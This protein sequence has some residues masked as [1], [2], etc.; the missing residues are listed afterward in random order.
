[1]AKYSL[2]ICINESKWWF[3]PDSGSSAASAPTPAPKPRTA[4]P[5]SFF[6]IKVNAY[7]MN[8]YTLC[9]LYAFQKP[10]PKRV[11][12]I[13][14]C[15]ADNA[16]E[17]T[18]TEGEVIIVDGEEDKEWWVSSQPLSYTPLNHVIWIEAPNDLSMSCRWATLTGS[19]TGRGFSRFHL[20]TSSPTDVTDHCLAIATGSDVS[21]DRATDFYNWPYGF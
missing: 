10:K 1:M 11:K 21:C 5:V 8:L 13:Y 6:K 19:R 14:N 20:Y 4:V 16:D 18:F 7:F 9:D 15:Q 2:S 3:S 17:L 12:A